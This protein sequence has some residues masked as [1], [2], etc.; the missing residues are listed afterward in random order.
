MI[1]QIYQDDLLCVMI[2]FLN[3]DCHENYN[4]L[5]NNRSFG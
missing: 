1:T 2:V 4:L 3:A 5:S